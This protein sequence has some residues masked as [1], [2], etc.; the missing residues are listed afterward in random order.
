MTLT[1]GITLVNAVTGQGAEMDGTTSV[2]MRAGIVK[3][4]IGTLEMIAET[5]VTTVVLGMMTVKAVVGEAA[6]EA[7]VG[8]VTI[9]AVIVVTM[10]AETGVETVHTAMIMIGPRED[11]TT[12]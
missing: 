1:K 6:V 11:A 12:L 9:S 3:D 10:V 4:L 7:I 2:T 8:H 5:V